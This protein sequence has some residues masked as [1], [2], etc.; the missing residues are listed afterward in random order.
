M[1]HETGMDDLRIGIALSGGGIRATIFHLGVLKWMAENEMLEK[2]SYIS[3]VSGASLCIGLVYSCNDLKWP[4]SSQFIQ[5]VLPQMEDILLNNDIQKTALLRVFPFWL[6]RR[7]NILAKVIEQKWGIHGTMPEL[8]G[9]PT[10]CVNCTTYE[11]GKRF[12]ITRKKMGD[13]VV[14]YVNEHHFP[15]SEA[16]AASAGF[17][18]LIGPY[19]LKRSNYEWN[20]SGYTPKKPF[21]AKG[22]CYH[23]WDGGVYDNL[24]LEPIF[25]IS[26]D[27][28]GGQLAEGIDYVIVSNAGAGS[29]F[30]KWIIASNPKRLLDIAMDQVTFLRSRSVVSYMKREKNGLFFNIGNNAHYLLEDAPL[31]SKEKEQV[32]KECL[33]EYQAS[34]VQNYGTTLR[35]P[36]KENYRMILRHGYEV[37]KCTYLAYGR[38]GS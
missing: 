2:L 18:V 21:V 3:S 11:T 35:K 9:R 37:A 24:G 32:I 29:G 1:Q 36:T 25:K 28:S 22:R 33:P 20:S 15:L 13:Y 27:K 23:L 31:S 16:M 7:V 12:L 38:K 30:K 19:K 6:T 14:G 17:P 5:N 26:A 10:W 4:S 34:Y 8:E